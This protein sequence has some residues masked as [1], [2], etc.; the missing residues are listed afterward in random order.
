[1]DQN[2]PDFPSIPAPDFGGGAPVPGTPAKPSSAPPAPGNPVPMQQ[3]SGQQPANQAA[4]T[5][6]TPAQTPLAAAPADPFGGGGFGAEP[7]LGGFGGDSGLG[8]LNTASLGGGSDKKKTMMIVGGGVAALVLSLSAI[9]GYFYIQSQAA[10]EEDLSVIRQPQTQDE[11]PDPT[12][13]D[14]A[15]ASESAALSITPTP[16]PSPT[17]VPVV[18]FDESDYFSIRIPETWKVETDEPTAVFTEAYTISAFSEGANPVRVAIM[19]IQLSEQAIDFAIDEEKYEIISDEEGENNGIPIRQVQYKNKNEPNAPET[20]A[21]LFYTNNLSYQVSYI[22]NKDYSK[23]N[24]LDMQ[25]LKVIT[26]MEIPDSEQPAD[27]AE[28]NAEDQEATA[29]AE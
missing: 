28:A 19:K 9:F 7:A 27:P 15:T 29:S 17:D 13:T 4:T 21:A 24:D 16:E 8:T 25:M 22:V 20:F 26:D 6:P 14:S 23:A 1:M 10:A 11:E 12:S 5:P 18:V 2:L 3:V